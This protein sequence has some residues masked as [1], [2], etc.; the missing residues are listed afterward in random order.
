[1]E[2]LAMKD[3]YKELDNLQDELD[4]LTYLGNDISYEEYQKRTNEITTRMDEINKT[5][6]AN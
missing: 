1:M 2:R 3:M 6:A 4:N 5:L